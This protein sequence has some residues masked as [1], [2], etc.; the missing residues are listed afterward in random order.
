MR[1]WRRWMRGR[2]QGLAAAV[3]L[4][5]LGGAWAQPALQPGGVFITPEGLQRYLQERRDIDQALIEHQAGR[6]PEAERRFTALAEQGSPVGR[7][8]LAMMHV[9]R[10]AA[11]SSLDK[12]L[13][14]LEASAAQGFVRSEHALGEIYER[15]L[16]GR[17]DHVRSVQWYLKAAEHGHVDAQVAAGT[18]Y[19]LGRGVP[20]DLALAAEWYRRAALQGEMGAQYLLGSMYEKGLGVPKDARLAR[21]WYDAAA[22][23]G[24]EAAPYKVKEMDE[25]LR[26]KAL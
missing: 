12:A 16:T 3:G 22:A 11:Q 13:E 17:P 2:V 20:Q 21:Y 14:L 6:W 24:D 7:Y 15:G 19:Y 1:A 26:G 23:N 4:G 5:L 10:E 25:I 8:N 9:R 18:A